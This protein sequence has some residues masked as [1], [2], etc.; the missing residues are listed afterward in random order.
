MQFS[1]NMS[2]STK[3]L[4]YNLNE[5]EYIFFDE[6][7]IKYFDTN[8]ILKRFR[9]DKEFKFNNIKHAAAWSILDKYNKFHE[10]RRLL[11]LDIKLYSV[12]VDKLIHRKLLKN[13]NIEDYFI[14]NTK[15]DNDV[16][17]EKEIMLEIDK[18]IIMA[19]NCQQRGFENELKRIQ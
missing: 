6:Y 2:K 5:N 16:K 10:A 14:M 3:N 15:L 11:E 9:D 18:Y 8:I 4:I 7:L 12:K 13:K 1:T 17:R 19:N